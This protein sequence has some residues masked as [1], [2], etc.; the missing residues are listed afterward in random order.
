M[1]LQSQAERLK[2]KAEETLYAQRL[3]NTVRR[4]EQSANISARARKE[5]D[6]AKLA[7][8]IAQADDLPECLRGI[9][10][11][12]QLQSL[13]TVLEC[14]RYKA[15]VALGMGYPY[16]RVTDE[17]AADAAL[18]PTNEDDR[19]RLTAA[20]LGSPGKWSIRQTIREL[21]AYKTERRQEDPIKVLERKLVGARIPS[22]FPTPAALCT[23]MVDLAGVA[24]GHRV[25]EPSAGSGNIATA[26]R[27][28]G[29]VP[30]CVEINMT[31]HDLLKAKG[32][33]TMRGDFMDLDI[34][35]R[36]D[37][38][39][40]NP[41]FENGQDMAHVRRAFQCLKPG[42]RL[43]AITSPGPYYKSDRQSLDFRAW[44]DEVG[45]EEIEDLPAG[46]FDHKDMTQRTGVAAKLLV[47]RKP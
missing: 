34:A 29:A 16:D 22:F 17:Q 10:T 19:R 8:R 30:V 32:F 31:L 26:T 20:G 41:P 21:L 7:I 11:I 43:V 37:A 42:G 47:I 6:H 23:R 36:F 46:T 39:V 24:A 27:D 28:A 45:I 12:A 40:M 35:E 2:S 1:S 14:G 4:A 38:A 33:E 3:T 9:K 44:L 18:Y 13:L 25:L 5:I 15:G